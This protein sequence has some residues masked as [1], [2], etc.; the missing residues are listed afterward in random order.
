VKAT[1]RW[2]GARFR[3]IALVGTIV[4]IAIALWSQRGALRAFDW[5][6]AWEPLALSVAL[7]ALPVLLQAA[8]FW[9]LLRRLGPRTPLGAALLVWMRSFLVRYAP[10][11]AL[12]FVVR[13]RAT[14][15]LAATRAHVWTATAYE[16]LV[17]LV[18]G[19][20]ACV[21]AFAAVRVW[22]P[23][24][25]VAILAA[26]AGVAVSLRPR[27]LGR[28]VQT[29]LVRRGL[30]VPELLRGRVLVAAIAVNAAGW[31]A[32]GSAALVLLRGLSEDV[33]PALGWITASYAFAW[34]LGFL[35]PLL[36]GGLGLRDATLAAALAP[37]YG[38]GPATAL[39]LALRL[40]NTLGELLAI[41]GV[42]SA[43]RLRRR[44]VGRNLEVLER[45]PR[46]LGERGSC[47]DAAEDRAPRLVDHE[48]D[49]QPRP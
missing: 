43:S 38:A 10:S 22:P 13:V 46:D 29:L 12:A 8:S 14:E 28:R 48:Q 15:Q 42:E 18:A 27:F 1:L 41:G 16:Q 49:H 20:A 34:L 6:L 36:P 25:A 24:L 39:A 45:E 7:F 32:S 47:D 5:R 26:S 19:A 35:V 17:A 21:A 9:I 4:G 37:H 30:H 44:P 11:G 31:V 3:T 23:W 2:L 33:P 40:A